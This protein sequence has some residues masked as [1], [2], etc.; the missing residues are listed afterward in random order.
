LSP[1]LSHATVTYHRPC[2]RSRVVSLT[3]LCMRACVS[4]GYTDW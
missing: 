4:A 1:S 3:S 2:D